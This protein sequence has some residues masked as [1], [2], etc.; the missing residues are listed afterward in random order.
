MSTRNARPR[1]PE[2]LGAAGRAFWRP[3][4]GVY[5]LSPTEF[6]LLARACRTV[7]LLDAID[8]ALADDGVTVEGSVGQVCAHP[9]LAS[10]ALQEATLDTLIR[11]MALPLPD[12]AEGQRRSP[13]AMEAAQ[14]RWRSK[15]GTVA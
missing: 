6:V 12:Q 5:E 15:R 9:L 10:K 11:A 3:A 8:A 13:A 1:A 4:T 7:D 14:Q 2:G